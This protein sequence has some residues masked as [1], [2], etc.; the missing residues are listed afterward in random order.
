MFR[1]TTDQPGGVY[2]RMAAL[3]QFSAAGFGNTPRSGS[4]RARTLSEPPGYTGRGPPVRTTRITSVDFS[5][6]YLPAPY[7]ARGF[8]AAG[9][10]SFNSE[11]LTIVNS[12]NRADQLT[13]LSYEVRSWDI[14]P[15]AADLSRSAAGSPADGDVTAA[16]PAGPARRAR[17]S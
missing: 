17:R 3:P 7:A 16:G 1:Y 11:S 4:T 10:W 12:E 13:N 9:D 5:S 2:L 14:A 8:T 6:Q 15:T